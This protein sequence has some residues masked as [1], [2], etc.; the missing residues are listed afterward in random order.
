MILALLALLQGPP[1]TVGDTIWLERNVDLPP[2]AEIRAGPWDS[3]ADLALLG[4]PVI[5]REGNRATIAYPAVAW[6]AGL[7]TVLVPGP[8]VIRQNGVTDSMPAEPRAIL[9]QSVLPAGQPPEKLPVQPEAGLVAEQITSP[10]P[11]VVLLLVAA[12]LFWPVAWWWLRPGPSMAVT[13]LGGPAEIPLAI[14]AEA[15]EP[16]AV[17]AAA[18]RALRS[19]IT[20]Q[21]RGIPPG[22]VTERLIRV[23]QEQRPGWPA[24]ELTTVLSELEAAQFTERGS[25]EIQGLVEEAAALRERLAGAA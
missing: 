25:R 19:A 21:V 13:R 17:A 3:D 15:G 14:W 10:W 1:P 9:V 5:R 24:E 22:I 12:I 7:H 4:H 23:V 11:V 8:V 2:G 16:R 6:T 18:A 20:A